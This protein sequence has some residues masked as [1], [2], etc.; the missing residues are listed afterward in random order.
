MRRRIYWTNWNS[1]SP[2]IQRSYYTGFDVQPIITTDIR[3]PNGL[4][5]DLMTRKLYWAD[6]RLD[7]IERAD[8]DGKNR[9]VLSKVSPQHPFDIAVYGDYIYWTDWVL[10]AVL[11]A[12]KYT[13]E[14]V[15]WLRKEV[16]RSMGIVAI[17]NDTYQCST[18]PCYTLNGG[19]EDLCRLDEYGMVSRLFLSSCT[20]IIFFFLQ[21]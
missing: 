14:D 17:H 10:H 4:T 1:R 19:C 11:R 18:N 3:M 5:L 2:A 8:L 13:G 7:K 20:S 21:Y 6:A 15:T 9:V 12:N 16:P